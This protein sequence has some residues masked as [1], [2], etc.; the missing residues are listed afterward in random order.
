VAA[1]LSVLALVAASSPILG[2][3]INPFV[4]AFLFGCL[5]AAYLWRVHG[6][7]NIGVLAAVTA[8]SVGTFEILVI[9]A[10]VFQA[11]LEMLPALAGSSS[12]PGPTA[13]VLTGML[14]AAILSTAF[15]VLLPSAWSPARRTAAI[16]VTAGAGGVLGLI[17][18]A[19]DDPTKTLLPL[20][21][22]WQGGMA[23]V[24]GALAEILARPDMSLPPSAEQALPPA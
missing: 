7:T 24:L 16:G 2:A 14:G 1:R 19:L 15:M 6:V 9:A 21:C 10:F 5:L 20:A 4:G 11:V 18:F 8:V 13:I 17:G 23:L 12:A 3:A 22:V